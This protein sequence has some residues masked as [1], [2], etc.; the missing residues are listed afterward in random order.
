M[1]LGKPVIVARNTNM[2]RIAE[3]SNFGM[4]VDYGDIAGLDAALSRLQWDP[5][6]RR[7]LGENARKAYEQVYSWD[8]MQERLLQLYQEV[9]H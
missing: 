5:L 6:F 8:R 7:R 3:Q 1:M 4:V 2:D 9:L